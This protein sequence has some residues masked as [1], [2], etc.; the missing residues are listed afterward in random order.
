MTNKPDRE[1]RAADYTVDLAERVRLMRDSLINNSVLFVSAPV[2]IIL[3]PIM[4]RGLGAE[5]YGLWVAASSLGSMLWIDFGIQVSSARIVAQDRVVELG[6][7][8]PRFVEAAWSA[9]LALGFL[10]ALLIGLFGLGLTQ[11]LHLS[12]E[13]IR[14]APIF[15]GLAGLT[16][17]GSQ[18]LTFTAAVLN[19]L[20]RFDVANYLAIGTLLAGA[21]G[22]ITV[23]TMGG[24]LLAVAIWQV[25]LNW[26]SLLLAIYVVRRLEP[27]IQLGRGNF[28]W[29]WLRPYLAFGLWSQ[30][31]DFSKNSNLQAAP[32]L[33]GTVLNSSAISPFAVGQKFPTAVSRLQGRALDV[34]FPAASQSKDSGATRHLIE[35]GTRWMVVLMLPSYLVLIISA[36]KLLLAWMGDAPVDT[37]AVLR[38]MCAGM[39]I[40]ALGGGS[41]QVLWGRGKAREIFWVNTAAL[42]ANLAVTFYALHRIGLQGAAWGFLASMTVRSMTLLVLASRE[43]QVGLFSLLRG[44]LKGIYIPAAACGAVTWGVLSAPWHGGWLSL[45]TASFAGGMAYVTALHFGGARPEERVLAREV[46]LSPFTLVRFTWR[47]LRRLQHQIGPRYR[48]YIFLECVYRVLTYKPERVTARLEELFANKEDPYHT[49]GPESQERYGYE[50]A[51]LDSVRGGDKFKRALEIG[52]AEGVF[53]EALAPRCE[54]LVALDNSPSALGRARKRCAHLDHVQLQQYDMRTDPLPG[55]FDMIIVVALGNLVLPSEYRKVCAAIVDALRPGGYLLVGEVR[56]REVYENAR[57]AKWFFM[58]GKWVLKHIGENPALKKIGEYN[59]DLW[60]HTLFK[61]IPANVQA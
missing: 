36:P 45:I 34:I 38:L 14:I 28:K 27:R 4:V 8:M 33:I 20:R 16:F 50:L 12:A 6:D 11:G 7:Q 53:T 57:W 52:C 23:L 37:V 41:E 49:F 3:V 9:D 1:N 47:S 59:L 13:S 30:L 46:L 29:A 24:S 2:G 56:G 19:G 48:A 51:M 18:L 22:I 60:M 32:L 26:S 55:T 21:A 39:A 5:G 35:V 43:G 25:L 54:S 44:S 40:A 31:S 42:A 10:V 17:W 61:K 58:G 15:F